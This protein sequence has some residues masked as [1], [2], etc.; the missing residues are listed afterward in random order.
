MVSVSWLDCDVIVEVSLYTRHLGA[1]Y[2]GHPNLVWFDNI[3]TTAY[4]LTPIPNRESIVN[5]DTYPLLTDIIFIPFND[6]LI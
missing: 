4:R 3:L 5:S 2:S 1:D 6:T